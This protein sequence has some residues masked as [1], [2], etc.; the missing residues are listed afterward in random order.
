[1]AICDTPGYLPGFEDVRALRDLGGRRTRDGR[2]VRRGCFYRGAAL[3]DL[4]EEERT[5]ALGLNIR[6]VLDL[7]AEG[8]RADKADWVPE[9]AD[10]HHVSGMYADDGDEVDFSPAGIARLQDRFASEGERFMA[11]LY[12]GMAHDNPA[13]H[14]LADIIRAGQ[15]PVYFHCTA[16]KDRTGV[17]AAFVYILLG[18]DDA[19]IMD[20]FLLTNEYRASIIHMP[21]E[22]R[23][24]GI[25]KDLDDGWEKLNSVEPSSLQAFLD[26]ID[27]NHASREAWLEDEFG[28]SYADLCDLRDRYLE[29]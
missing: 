9:G 26:A 16:G 7:R 8:E 20:D 13:L 27:C 19:T 22:L 23:P 2:L 4:S 10:Y 15:V 29:P 21:K 14:R 18:A 6:S 17:A 24:K 11:N 3:A 5:R 1:M 12:A 25:P 28:I